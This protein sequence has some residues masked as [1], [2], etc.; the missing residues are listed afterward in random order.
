MNTAENS[1]A[2]FLL[3]MT[4]CANRIFE[5]FI[6]NFEKRLKFSKNEFI[7]ANKCIIMDK[8]RYFFSGG[9]CLCLH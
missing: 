8:E 9:V 6:K 4:R 3:K 5:H 1:S 7:F 2:V